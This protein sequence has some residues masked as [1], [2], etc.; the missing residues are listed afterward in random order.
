LEYLQD[1]FSA[2]LAHS[3]LRVYVAAISAYHAPLGG[4]SV[5]KDPLVVRF[6]RGALR[7]KPPVRPRSLRGTS[8]PPFEP[9]KESWDHHLSAKTALLLALTPSLLPLAWPRLFFT[10]DRAPWPVVLQAFCPPPFR[11]PDQQKLNC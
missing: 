3:T 8:P 4:M 7:L 5:G 9:I 11:D 6:L 2:G 10:P 1:R